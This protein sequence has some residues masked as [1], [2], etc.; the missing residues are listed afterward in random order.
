MQTDDKTCET[1]KVVR[2]NSCPKRVREVVVKSGKNAGTKVRRVIR[3]EGGHHL[4]LPG[5]PPGTLCPICGWSLVPQKAEKVIM[6][7]LGP[8]VRN[9]LR[10]KIGQRTL[11]YQFKRY[12]PPLR[13]GKRWIMDSFDGKAHIAFNRR[14]KIKAGEEW[15]AMAWKLT[16]DPVVITNSE[17]SFTP[18]VLT[19]M[20]QHPVIRK[21]KGAMPLIMLFGHKYSN[22]SLAFR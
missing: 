17:K 8:R 20:S 3:P 21:M 19:N 4:F 2:V 12:V 1:P 11:E 16:A 9:T 15:R 22:F 5:D 13:N 14:H 18:V 7:P 10:H 6:I